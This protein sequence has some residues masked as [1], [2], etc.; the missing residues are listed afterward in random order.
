[1]AIKDSLS[2]LVHSDL[3]Q[4]G[5]YGSRHQEKVLENEKRFMAKMIGGSQFLTL[6]GI[7]KDSLTVTWGSFNETAGI[8]GTLLAIGTGFVTSLAFLNVN[9]THFI[10]Y[11]TSTRNKF[12]YSHSRFSIADLEPSKNDHVSTL[13]D[14]LLDD[15]DVKEIANA[16][17]FVIHFKNEYHVGVFNKAKNNFNIYRYLN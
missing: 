16:S 17:S 7:S 10:F 13:T 4:K 12:I 1:V 3:V 15:L 6:S 9:S 5:T 14:K 2:K 8:G 11:I